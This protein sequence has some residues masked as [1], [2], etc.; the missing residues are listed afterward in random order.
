MNRLSLGHAFGQF[1]VL[2][3]IHGVH[4][5]PSVSSDDVAP[6]SDRESR[7]H[8]RSWRDADRNS[9]EHFV[10]LSS[11]SLSL[12]PHPNS[13]GN[14]TQAPIECHTAFPDEPCSDAVLWAMRNSHWYYPYLSE[15]SSF[16][17]FQE[18]FY[19]GGSIGPVS[20]SPPGHDNCTL[21]CRETRAK[22][23]SNV[24]R[25][26]NGNPTSHIVASEDTS[27]TSGR[28]AAGFMTGGR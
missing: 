8:G 28:T 9:Q 5:K 18:W 26:V 25:L 17:D 13:P 3:P 15:N 10:I 24:S 27:T 20:M 14:T 12:A 7:K 22:L 21:P 4:L 11:T 2:R 1:G 6:K 19:H 23:R 16:E